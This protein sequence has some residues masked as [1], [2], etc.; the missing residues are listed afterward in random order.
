VLAEFPDFFY[1]DP[2]YYPVGRDDEALLALQ[3]FPEIQANTEEFEAI[4]AQNDLAGKTT[5]SDAEKLLIYR[6]HKK[7]AALRFELSDDSYQFQIQ[8]AKTEGEGELISG[9]IDGQGAI[10]VLEKTASIAACPICLAAGTR[11]DTPQGPVLVQNLRPGMLVW[12]VDGSGRQVAQPLLQVG[13]TIVP[14]SHQ[15][16]HIVLEDGREVWVSPGH[17]T[18]DG[19]TVGE[20]QV[21]ESLD[22]S[23]ILSVQRVIYAG[24][25]TYDLLPGGETGFYWAN[26]ILLTSTLNESK[27]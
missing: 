4:L 8:V 24:Q 3:R 19:S 16:V 13:K 1:C 9:R 23:L 12:T 7:L 15:V 26:G 20:L 10:T 11:I 14:A 18:A 25:A 5:F 27:P 21:G 17:L 22:G 2:D 6:E